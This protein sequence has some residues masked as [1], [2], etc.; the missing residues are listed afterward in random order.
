MEIVAPTRSH[1]IL[2]RGNTIA[3]VLSFL[4]VTAGL[5]FVS[6]SPIAIVSMSMA[7]LVFC[8]LL[9][10]SIIAFLTSGNGVLCEQPS[11]AS[12]IHAEARLP[13]RI[14]IENPSSRWPLLFLTAEL[15][16]MC[17]GLILPSPK[18]FLGIL[19]IRTIG[20]FEWYLTSRKRG[21]SHLL[22]VQAE[23]SFPGSMIQRRFYFAFDLPFTCLP[24]EYVLSSNIENLLR[25]QRRSVGHQPSGPA[26]SEEFVGVREYRP[27]DNPRNVCMSLST[28]LPDFPYQLVVREFQDPTDSEVCV[29]LDTCVPPEAAPDAVLM[30]YR[31]EKAISFSVALSRQLCERKHA[32][33]FLASNQD[34][35]VIDVMVKQ[36]HRDIPILER[37][38]SRLRPSRNPDATASL[39]RQQENRSDAILLFVSLNN[40]NRGKRFR[41]DSSLW[42]HP[43]W[44]AS[45]I[46]EVKSQ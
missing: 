28:R 12:E 24:T 25:G 44:Q 18:K 17:D 8:W 7:S 6:K 34:G 2:A 38:L 10:A 3:F 37:K 9:T 40:P 39:I 15:H 20:E 30:R 19:P 42:I 13:I 23:T 1:T 33:R 29:V 27:G 45:L 14:R 35:Q 22:G 26:A 4:W 46:Q 32:V 31:L 5:T 43:E 41:S 36:P 16:T 11:M 21:E